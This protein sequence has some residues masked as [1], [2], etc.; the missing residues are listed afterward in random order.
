MIAILSSCGS[1]SD[2]PFQYPKTV[3]SIGKIYD[4]G[5]SGS[6]ADIRVHAD[7]DIS[8]GIGNVSEVRLIISKASKSL[9]ESDVLALKPGTYFAATSGGAATQVFKPDA[10]IKDVD[11]E[12]IQND[13]DYKIYIAALGKD[14]AIRLSDP[15]GFTL[16]DRPIYA[17]SYVG[18]WV[19]TKLGS[20][21]ISLSLDNNYKGT[22]FYTNTF[23][24]CCGGG[25]DAIVT[26]V[27]NETA[28]TSFHF[29]QYLGSYKGGHC[30]A[31]V[32]ATGNFS[33]DIRLILGNFPFSD[34]DGSRTV[35]TFSLTRDF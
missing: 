24:A 30:E 20:L 6:A 18:V 34:C 23:H 3:F 28:I 32:E 5:N 4:V 1:K 35:T 22:L 9:S 27:V 2:P 17:G 21:P 13:R 29:D 16:M 11:N 19:D 33:D 15:R 7:F 14:N 8:V 10:S 25:S 12:P 26:M 31:T